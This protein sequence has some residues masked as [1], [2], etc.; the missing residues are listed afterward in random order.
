MAH[1]SGG[2]LTGAMVKM[3]VACRLTGGRRSGA[4]HSGGECVCAVLIIGEGRADDKCMHR[5]E[6]ASH[7]QERKAGSTPQG[8]GR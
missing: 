1:S 8:A 5:H 6:A 2:I 7:E 3:C 4:A